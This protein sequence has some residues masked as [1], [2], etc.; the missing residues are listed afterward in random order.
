M[1][2]AKRENR[3]FPGPQ[4][5]LLHVRFGLVSMLLAA[6]VMALAVGICMRAASTVW[7][8][9]KP[10]CTI[11]EAVDV[12]V[13]STLLIGLLSLLYVRRQFAYAMRPIAEYRS[14]ESSSSHFGLQSVGAGQRFLIVHLFN[15]GAGPMLVRNARY[16]VAFDGAEA[17]V[18]GEFIVV[19]DE[20][21]RRELRSGREIVIVNVGKGTAMESR[22]QRPVFEMSLEGSTARLPTSL[23]VRLEFEG[24][25]GDR[26]VKEMFYIPRRGIDSLRVPEG[27][28]L[29]GSDSPKLTKQ[30]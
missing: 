25:L 16:R 4:T 10:L 8:L 24:V 20:L 18:Y 6:V 29:A 7:T 13:A 26:Y 2:I 23:D 17:G 28:P 19:F 15:V 12:K 3:Q 11:S 5:A 14:W 27:S 21:F 22:G 9:P 1:S 30:E